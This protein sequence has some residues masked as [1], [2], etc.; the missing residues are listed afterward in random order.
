MAAA[1]RCFLMVAVGLAPLL[2]GAAGGKLSTRFYDSKCPSLQSVV[3]SA[4]AQAVAAEPRMGASILRLFFHDCFVNGCDASILLDDTASF[5]GEKNAGPNANSVR[6][7]DVI[8]AIKA[9]VEASCS[10]VVSCADIVALAARDS[11]NLLG[12]PTWT[13]Q[14][15]RRDALNASQSAANSNLPGPGSSLATLITMFGNKGLSP[16]DM[17]ALSGAHTIGHARCTTFHDRIYNDANINAS[18]A[19]LR[20]QTCPQSSGGDATLAPIDVSTPTW[21]DTTYFENLANKQGL[22]H[23]DQELYNG[24]SQ[25]V[26]VRVYM[27]NP[28]IF[29]LDF[30]KAMG[31]MGSLMPSADTPTEI[32]LDCKKIN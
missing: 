30:A 3:R 13:V 23:S 28:D 22:F 6:G 12:G 18:F 10:G 9:Q 16:R 2:A 27:R 1:V 31:K 21:F 11:V 20:Q 7:Y 17:T 4:T 24:G 5:T 26:L 32:R 14:L 29:A 8:D 15:G 19:A 25:D